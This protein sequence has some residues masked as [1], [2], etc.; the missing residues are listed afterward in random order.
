MA[1]KK[2]MRRSLSLKPLYPLLF[3]SDKGTE[4][5]PAESVTTE[6]VGE[7]AFGLS[8]LPK[9]WTLPYIVVSDEL[10]SLYN[11]CREADRSQLLDRWATQIITAALNVGIKDQDPIIVRSSGCSEGLEE[12]GKFYS[13][14]GT[15]K[16]ILQPLT[17]CLGQ[18][19]SDAELS[20]Q[21][22]PIIIQKYAIPISAKGHLSNERR[23]YE[24]K[25]D[26]LGEFEEIKTGIGKPFKINLRNWRKKIVVDNLTDEPLA[27]NLTAHV[28]EVLKIPAAWGS[29]RD[30]R[31]HF[32][33]V[34][35]GKS[36]YLVQADQEHGAG[37]VDPTK[38]HQ[39]MV[40]VSSEF[41]PKCL[42]QINETH[43]P[44]YNKIHNVFIYSKLGLP[45][46][47]IYVLDDQTLIAGLASG[48]V[49]SVLEADLSE[50]VKG[51]LVIRMDLATDDMKKRQLLPRT[52]EV[53]EL[54]SAI[55]WLKE[56]SEE[57]KRHAIQDDVCFI[58]HNFVPSVS[59]AFAYA[60]PGERKV[61]IETL[62][63]LPEG[64]YYNAHDKFIVDTQSPRVQKLSH[65]DIAQFEVQEKPCFK[66]FFVAPDKDGR[67]TTQIL[68][69]PYD[70]SLSI[71]KPEWVKEIALESRRIAEEEGKPLSIMWFVG[72]P[73]GVCS[74]PI[75]PWY[76]EPCDLKVNSRARTHR[77]K[78]PFD[79]SLIIRTSADI[80]TLRQEAEKTHFSVR[81]VSIQ[82]REEALLRDKNTLRDIGNLAQKIGA[83]ILLEG[84][85]LSHAYY[86]LMETNAIVEVLHPFEDFEDKREFN[87]LVRDKVP[88]N[89]ERGGE[90]VSKTSL[91]GEP[92][93]RAL[94]DKLVEEAFEV[95]D[96][97]DQDSIVG[98]LAD[99]SEIIDEILSQLC[100][101]RDELLARQEQKQKKAGGFKDGLVLLETKNPLPTKRGGYTGD[102]LF[103]DINL[104]DKRDLVAMADREVIELSHRME[105]WSDRREH[106]AA[107]E[108]ILRI[109]VPMVR[110][111][112][113]AST[114]ET[115]ID[116][117]SGNVILAKINGTR[118]GSKH[119][120]ELSIF[121]PQKQ[122]KLF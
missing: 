56:K 3:I 96:A 72:V 91:S 17:N 18:L 58:F 71:Q 73:L 75:F 40:S 6:K 33:W 86:Q 15:L 41:T 121:S 78:T 39:S 44:M 45:I 51:S 61:Q 20:K 67:W 98:E 13:T 81:R 8:C 117:D 93:L 69:N 46:A 48:Q 82:P 66:R 119:Q 101:S 7:K 47:K 106:Q 10:L 9:F 113:A 5:I 83:V 122:L 32:E 36:I 105:K 102:T 4:E 55:E 115:V 49:P 100:V 28:S 1:N 31:L 19:A 120:I 89:I 25:R 92:F 30:R 24:E 87:K 111:N 97:T 104:T 63:G 52:H 76:H 37:G 57:I 118:L 116:A 22:I 11:F 74:R 59:S 70:W 50:L 42:K 65:D 12:R 108:V 26:W 103:D 99:V 109:V 80:E 34:W 107:T 77:T 94:R 95:L 64:L 43:A 23:C 29:E 60:A 53:R 68:K 14:E 35:D 54:N 112:W 21:K 110:D 38:T 62:W 27:C 79:K 2:K 84:G 114:P 88:S 85:V 90:I 16:K